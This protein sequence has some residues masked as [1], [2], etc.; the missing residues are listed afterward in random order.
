MQRSFIESLRNNRNYSNPDLLQQL[1]QIY[2][3]KGSGTAF[4]PEVFDPDSL[5]KSD[6]ACRYMVVWSIF[7]I[8]GF[9]DATCV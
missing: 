6:Y 1:M 3:L 8:S 2:N 4:S 7:C 9:E 5:P